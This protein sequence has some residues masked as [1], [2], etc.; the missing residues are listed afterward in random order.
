MNDR[1]GTF[2]F[3]NMVGLNILGTIA[4]NFEQYKTK[5]VGLYSRFSKVVKKR[6]TKEIRKQD[7]LQLMAVQ[8]RGKDAISVRKHLSESQQQTNFDITTIRKDLAGCRLIFYTSRGVSAF[9]N[10][11]IMSEI[12]DIDW[13]RTKVH[14][15]TPDLG[16][17][18]LFQ[19]NNYVV[20]LNENQHSCRNYADFKGLWCEVQVQSA[21]NHV[22]SELSHDIMYKPMLGG[23]FGSKTKRDLAKQV[24]TVTS[25]HIRPAGH[26]LSKIEGDFLRYKEDN[27]VYDL[28]VLSKISK[29][30]N[31]VERY[32]GLKTLYEHVL[33]H[34][35]DPVQDLRNFPECLQNAWLSAER[36]HLETDDQANGLNESNLT[37]SVFKVIS[38][39]IRHYL[40]DYPKLAYGVLKFLYTNTRIDESH[41]E[42]CE[43]GELM[44]SHDR[45]IWERYGPHMQVVYAD[46]IYKEEN[47]D[48][49]APIVIRIA[50]AILGTEV[51]G[52]E[53]KIKSIEMSKGSVIY[54]GELARARRKAIRT[55][56]DWHYG[57]T[58]NTAKKELL[59]TL[60]GGL[61]VPRVTGYGSEVIRMLNNDFCYLLRRLSTQ[62]E[63]DDLYGLL[64]LEEKLF[65]LWLSYGRT[66]D[67]LE[68]NHKL[69]GSRSRLAG[70]IDSFVAL[71]NQNPEF[72]TYKL[73]VGSSP[74]FKQNWEKGNIDIAENKLYRQSEQKRLAEGLVEDY[75]V[76]WKN[77]LRNLMSQISSDLARFQPLYNFLNILGQKCPQVLYEFLNDFDELRLPEQTISNLI[78]P[79][80]RTD[81]ADQVFVLMTKWAKASVHCE[82]IAFVLCE[83]E[84]IVK[85]LI[86]ILIDSSLSRK[87]FRTLNTIASLSFKRF[88]D[89]K[90]FWKDEVFVPILSFYIENSDFGWID[91]TAYLADRESLYG[92][93]DDSEA[94]L[95]LYG[96]LRRSVLCDDAMKILFALTSGNPIRLLSFFK[97]RVD[98][99]IE[100]SGSSYEI[101]P[102]NIWRVQKVLLSS[103][104]LVVT[105]IVDWNKCYPASVSAKINSLLRKVY[106]NFTDD[107][108]KVLKDMV[109]G[110][111]KEILVIII[112][113]LRG[114]LGNTQLLPVL[115][116]IIASSNCDQ[117]IE[118]GV[119]G[120]L[121][122]YDGA[123]GEFG[124]RDRFIE[125]IKVIQ[126]WLK[127]DNEN[128]RNFADQLLHEYRNIAKSDQRWGEEWVAELEL[129]YG[130]SFTELQKSSVSETNN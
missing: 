95:A 102:D 56:C 26:M 72:Q 108:A 14:H 4:M 46:E 9:I 16:E 7:D 47:I 58:V 127:D 15:P 85:N 112:K 3:R 128:V 30:E 50:E 61:A 101:F 106:T 80:L 71:L 23:K 45:W 37:V 31:N 54:C 70:I 69:E 34:L 17:N 117:E 42:L 90:K 74:I 63:T 8:N 89:D 116:D 62:C 81:Y 78:V 21:L 130:E 87:D 79:L 94:E 27:A 12:F 6:L 120:V 2:P 129:E 18:S 86:K 64:K 11:G 82:Q 88:D 53:R 77:R 125:K 44:A 28:D 115:R 13:N 52:T 29:A 59:S 98:Q 104:E 96:L 38:Q 76:E 41:K 40:I 114:Y 60:L 1:N 55:L 110:G 83:S 48:S 73:L 5:G 122:E 39:I 66:M 121:S 107:I 24:E 67:N 118:R 119:A 35:T 20:K 19:S 49:V 68:I 65:F 51:D 113:M 126:S 109:S 93:L 57:C 92:D 100:H 91:A 103:P 105:T 99:F 84:R 111:S 32:S 124:V 43:L 36:T 10:K 75:S 123:F 33:P 97:N 25:C 22:V